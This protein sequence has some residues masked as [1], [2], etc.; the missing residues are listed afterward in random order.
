MTPQ[1]QQKRDMIRTL[2]MGQQPAGA[3]A[4]QP[5]SSLGADRSFAP[6]PGVKVAQEGQ[7]DPSSLMGSDLNVTE[8]KNLG[9]ALRM[10][11]A[12]SVLRDQ[13]QQGTRMGMKALEMLPGT[14]LENKIYS[15]TGNE[16]YQKYVQA[17]EAFSN[18]ALRADTGAQINE[19][20]I[21]RM[22]KEFM[23]APGDGEEV[24]QQKRAA[25]EAFLRAIMAASGSAGSSLPE[26]GTPV[27]QYT[28]DMSDDD[29]EKWLATQ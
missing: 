29:F 6:G 10:L 22:V 26:P 28:N 18:A 11:Q 17:R 2:L 7:F 19:S 25:R 13:E 15:A 20:E 27:I 12:E 24:L 8:A 4:P 1:E 3:P 9:W 23:P 16:D 14:S 5:V 21:P